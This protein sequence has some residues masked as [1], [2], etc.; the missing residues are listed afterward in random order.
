MI[1][2]Y[3]LCDHV[4]KLAHLARATRVKEQARVFL[5]DKESD[6]FEWEDKNYL[7]VFCL[8]LDN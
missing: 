3:Y 7:R 5:R 2:T 6:Y 8:T 4:V 1:R